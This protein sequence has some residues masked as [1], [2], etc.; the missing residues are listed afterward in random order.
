MDLAHTPQT[1]PPLRAT[2]RC[3]PEALEALGR[4]HER[5]LE[6]DA[7]RRRHRRWQ[8]LRIALLLAL[9]LGLLVLSMLPPVPMPAAEGPWDTSPLAT[10][11]APEVR[12]L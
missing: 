2:A 1:G 6:I 7:M 12:V 10:T 3:S 5:L 11:P 9:L 8:R 4:L